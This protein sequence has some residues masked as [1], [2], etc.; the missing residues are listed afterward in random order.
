MVRELQCEIC[1]ES[2]RCEGIMHLGCWCSK[3]KVSKEKREEI[4]Q[5]ADD[6]VCPKCLAG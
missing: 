4:S 6:C 1:G 3:V 2:F 5:L